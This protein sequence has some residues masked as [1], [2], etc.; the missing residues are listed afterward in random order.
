MAC[1]F[2]TIPKCWILKSAKGLPN[3]IFHGKVV[4]ISELCYMFN[5]FSHMVYKLFHPFNKTSQ[6]L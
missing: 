6:I 2:R 1:Y 5:E 4:R 3:P